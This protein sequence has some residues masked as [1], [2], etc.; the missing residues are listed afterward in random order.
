MRELR[1]RGTQELVKLSERLLGSSTREASDRAFLREVAPGLRNGSGE[2][3]AGL[4]AA[5]IFQSFIKEGRPSL[6]GA[7]FPSL[8]CRDEIVEAMRGR[9]AAQG[10]ALIERAERATRGYF[11]LLGLRAVR[12]GSSIDWRLE[13]TSGKRTPLRHWSTIDY[14]DPR[15]AGDKKVTWE[16]NR[17]GHFV[18]LGQAYWMTGDERYAAA[19]VSQAI[20]WMDANPPNRG[21][22]WT[23][24]LEV[25]FRSISWLWALHLFAGSRHLTP[26][27]Q[28]RMLKFLIAHGHHIQTYV[29]HYFS[30]NTHLTGEALG[31]FY[32]GTALPELRRA[33]DWRK[34]GSRIM[35]EQLP[36]QVSRRWRLF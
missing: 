32:L 10:R 20:S 11:D 6:P 30:P 7:F 29:S 17:H 23:S 33:S 1:V 34:L 15:I 12:F 16:L 22:N 35:I 3:T 2:A 19:F 5:R 14:L 36:L 28:L 24:S 27:F 13:P 31:L 9:F 18:T 4:I 26:E 21:I 8:S 25:A